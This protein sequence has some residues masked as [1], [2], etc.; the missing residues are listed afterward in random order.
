MSARPRTVHRP[1][2]PSGK[3]PA[4]ARLRRRLAPK[5]GTTGVQ[6]WHAARLTQPW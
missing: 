5:L 2:R 3:H 1:L 4:Q 6:L